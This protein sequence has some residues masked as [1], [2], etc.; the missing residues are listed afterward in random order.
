MQVSSGV[1][2]RGQFIVE[3]I[4]VLDVGE[5]RGVQFSVSRARNLLCQE[6]TVGRG[7]GWIVD[8][9]DHQ[10]WCANP[11]QLFTAIEIANCSA[12]R[13]IPLRVCFLKHFLSI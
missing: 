2:K 1:Q 5:V 13:R 10:S 12:T 3:P 4:L 9:S 8:S 11:A 7:S 6:A